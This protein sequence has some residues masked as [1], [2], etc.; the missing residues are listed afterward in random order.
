MSSIP[1]LP[2]DL[3]A[4]PIKPRK[5]TETERR[6]LLSPSVAP[7]E[8]A[9][10]VYTPSEYDGDRTPRA[11]SP[12]PTA[13]RETLADPTAV[14][15]PRPYRGFPSEEAYLD[16]LREWAESK[17]YIYHETALNGFYGHTT[18]AEYASRP[19][20]EMSLGIKEKWRARKARKEENKRAEG[21]RRGVGE[22]RATVA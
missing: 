14:A 18:M 6:H 1:K 19:K 15:Q 17:K 2:Q 9:S 22:R 7:S 11:A 16:A 10:M 5:S 8:S 12:A 3:T 21:D 13:R 4:L 20:I